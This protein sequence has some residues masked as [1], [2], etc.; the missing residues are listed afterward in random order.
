MAGTS[1]KCR[2]DTRKIAELYFERILRRARLQGIL[3]LGTRKGMSGKIP[4]RAIGKQGLHVSA[5]GLG[6]M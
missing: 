3:D 5:Q 1:L 6:I 2:T 4:Q